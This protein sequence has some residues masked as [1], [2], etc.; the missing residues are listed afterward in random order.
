MLKVGPK[1]IL[2]LPRLR[3]AVAFRFILAYSSS[4]FLLIALLKSLKSRIS[5]VDLNLEYPILGWTNTHPALCWK[6]MPAPYTG[7]D[8][9]YANE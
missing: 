8:L 4:S 5:S 6:V 3:P 2:T 9:I 7:V 1:P